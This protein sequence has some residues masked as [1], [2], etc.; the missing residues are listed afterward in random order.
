MRNRGTYYLQGIERWPDYSWVLVP[1]I[2]L[3]L[4]LCL[5]ASADP[6]HM[7]DT[8]EVLAYQP[9][10]HGV[11]KICSSKAVSRSLLHF[12]FITLALNMNHTAHIIMTA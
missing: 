3:H 7:S 1:L 2:Q 8:V 11:I 5:H 10:A 9:R 12:K 6:A 4:C